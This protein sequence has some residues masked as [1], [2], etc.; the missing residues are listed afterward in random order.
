MEEDWGGRAPLVRILH[1]LPLCTDASKKLPTS[2]ATFGRGRGRAEEQR[3]YC[4]AAVGMVQQGQPMTVAAV[5]LGVGRGMGR[6]SLAAA[7]VDK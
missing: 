1:T 6:G 3:W 7:V 2:N 4:S 5:L